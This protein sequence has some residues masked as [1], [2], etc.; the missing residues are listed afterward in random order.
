MC[1]RVVHVKIKVTKPYFNFG[2]LP[3]KDIT[4]NL[5]K[6]IAD[7]LHY[8]KEKAIEN[9]V[10]VV[11][12]TIFKSE[13]TEYLK[14]HKNTNNKG[15]GYYPRLLKSINHYFKLK[16]PRDR[17]SLFKPVFL[18]VLNNRER[19]IQDLAFNLYVKGLSTRDISDI[20]EETYHK[21]LSRT[22]ISNI[23][24]KFQQERELWQ[25]RPI[26]SEYYI[27]YIDA[28]YIPVRRDTVEK[29]AFYTVMGLRKDL[30]REI[31]GVYNIPTESA[32]GWRSVI[33]DLKYRGL[34]KVLLVVA[35]GIT[36]LKSIIKIELPTTKLQ[37]CLVHKIRSIMLRARTRDKKELANDFKKVFKLEDPTYT[38]KQGKRN[39]KK[40]IDKW[41]KKYPGM[42]R[43]FNNNDLENYFAY[44]EFPYQIHRMIYTT[45]WIEKLHNLIRSTQKNRLSF[46]NPDSALNLVCAYI[47][48]KEMKLYMK[49]P[50]T[51]FY[52]VKDE[53]DDLLE[54]N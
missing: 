49:Y 34:K 9:I 50:V 24:K 54:L 37:T 28:L 7:L 30:K 10:K 27:I 48:D 38:I 47:M 35:D 25:T 40:Y 53:F 42:C 4:I 15:N 20:F 8:D 16:I 43:K 51:A 29:E 2:G 21:K 23:T 19:D 3:M 32:S 17:L 14:I 46:P 31:L 1:L 6:N 45:N 22:S 18:E 11:F 12:E 52:K 26:E 33:Q 39:L 5:E 36:G 44:L 13:R 41:R